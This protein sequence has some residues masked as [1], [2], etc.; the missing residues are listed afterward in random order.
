[1]DA[2]ADADG[3][4]GCIGV[5]SDDDDDEARGMS[6]SGRVVRVLAPEALYTRPLFSST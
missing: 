6:W 2:A 4:D 1:V 5:A 3:G